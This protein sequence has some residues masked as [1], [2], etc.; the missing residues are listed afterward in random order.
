MSEG[1]KEIC[2]IFA[3]GKYCK[4]EKHCRYLHFRPPNLKSAKY[5]DESLSKRNLEGAVAAIHPSEF[6]ESTYIARDGNLNSTSLSSEHR[7]KSSFNQS[8]Q[9]GNYEASKVTQKLKKRGPRSDF[10]K[11]T[12]QEVVNSHARVENESKKEC[13]FFSKFGRCRYGEKCRYVH[14][15]PSSVR[16]NVNKFSEE[17]QDDHDVRGNVSD[18]AVTVCRFYAKGY[19]R[20]GN[21]CKASHTIPEDRSYKGKGKTSAKEPDCKKSIG[22]AKRPIKPVATF[23]PPVQQ[24]IFKLD[25]LS[26]AEE[27][28][29]LRGKIY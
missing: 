10:H 27:R 18:Q 4:F 15:L 24:F 9:S 11:S 23:R 12:S 22:S 7:Y 19:C 2:K 17:R 29:K 13:S 21:R 14:S 26:N 6:V 25:S 1:H 8:Y 20:Y 3:S 16:Q 28:Q 5:Q